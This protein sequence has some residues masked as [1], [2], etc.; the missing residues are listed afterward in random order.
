MRIVLL[1]LALLGLMS[2]PSYAQDECLRTQELDRYRLLRRMSLDLRHRM[3]SYEEYLALDAETG[4]PEA[5]IDAL[6]DSDDFRLA[7]RRFHQDLLWPSIAGVQLFDQNIVLRQFQNQGASAGVWD[8]ASAGKRRTFRNGTGSEFCGDWEQTEWEPNGLP[9]TVAATNDQGQPFDQEGYVWVE[10]Y[11][12]ETIKVC[13]FAAQTS[14]QGL[15]RSCL[16]RRGLQDRGC[17]CGPNL[18]RCTS[19]VPSEAIYRAVTEQL[20]RMVDDHSVGGRPYSE[21]LTTPAIWMNGPL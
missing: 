9:K 5:T 15:E 6:L 10:A 2:S 17:G 8:I 14:D 4:V 7:M 16:E 18:E 11:W 19:E 21:L 3:P 20:L 12:G 1:T 13:A